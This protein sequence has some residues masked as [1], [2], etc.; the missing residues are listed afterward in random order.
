[1]S[2]CFLL[3]MQKKEEKKKKF[4]R[5]KIF[6]SFVGIIACYI[7][8][9]L[10]FSLNG[11]YVWTQSGEVRYSFGLSVTDL[12]QW[13]PKWARCQVFRDISGRLV[14]RGNILGYFYT[15]L[16]L[17]D[18]KYIHPTKRIIPIPKERTD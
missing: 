18:Q 9:Y 12:E 13:Q 11:R 17:I 15:P 4:S 3:T 8:S 1:M 14:L 6:L 10:P 5:N 16:I 7:I 2:K